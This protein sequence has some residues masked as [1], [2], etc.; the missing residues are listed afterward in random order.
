MRSLE[1][2]PNGE[3]ES[4]GRAHRPAKRSESRKPRLP[5][6]VMAVKAAAWVIDAVQTTIASPGPEVTPAHR[7]AP[8]SRPAHNILDAS[9]KVRKR[10]LEYSP[11]GGSTREVLIESLDRSG[12]RCGSSKGDCQMR[13]RPNSELSHE[14]FALLVCERMVHSQGAAVEAISFEWQRTAFL[15]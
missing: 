9:A 13:A 3:Q 11:T 7:R 12:V 4:C 1:V 10:I 15:D 5:A 8:N 2:R 14:H 6:L